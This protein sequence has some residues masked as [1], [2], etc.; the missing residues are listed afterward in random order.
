[1]FSMR[2]ITNQTAD[3]S[4]RHPD[5]GSANRTIDNQIIRR[6]RSVCTDEDDMGAFNEKLSM[7][8]IEDENETWKEM[9]V[10][11]LNPTFD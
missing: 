1:M 2:V 8:K 3:E 7:A 6:R 4:P 10:G 5:G 11:V 9:D